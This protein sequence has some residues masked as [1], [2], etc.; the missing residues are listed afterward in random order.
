MV[1]VYRKKVSVNKGKKRI[2]FGHNIF[3]EG[4]QMAK[5]LILQIASSLWGCGNGGGKEGESPSDRLPYWG[6]TRKLQ[7][8]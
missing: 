8:D 7:V 1:G 6:I 2:I 3:L 5:V 4:N